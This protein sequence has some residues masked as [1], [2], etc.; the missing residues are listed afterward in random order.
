MRSLPESPNRRRRVN[1]GSR[2][3]YETSFR[4]WRL[5]APSSSRR[6]DGSQNRRNR[7]SGIKRINGSIRTGRGRRSS[8]CRYHQHP[9]RKA[10]MQ[11][12][13]RQT[14]RRVGDSFRLE[15]SSRS[16]RV[17]RIAE[18]AQA[19]ARGVELATSTVSMPSAS[20]FP[21]QQDGESF[22]LTS[23]QPASS[24]SNRFGLVRGLLQHDAK[25]EE[26]ALGWLINHTS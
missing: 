3:R 15:C 25:T 9:S 1:L 11:S 26:I 6:L 19:L 17:V 2:V 8:R 21:L 10:M 20:G 18:C 14:G 16:S 7:F 24:N 23:M 13:D 12:Q 4:S 5:L 22:R